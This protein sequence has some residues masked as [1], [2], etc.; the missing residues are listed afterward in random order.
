MSAKPLPR[1]DDELDAQFWE[2]CARERLCF[3]RCS[4]CGTWRHLPR[5][6]CARC[7]S[8][9]WEWSESSGR[10][11]IFSWTVTHQA[12]FPAFAAEV[13]YAVVIVELE[14]GVRMVSRVRDLPID[15]LA[16]DLPVEVSFERV[17]DEAALPYFRPRSAA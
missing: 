8:T 15:A 1:P 5:R 4:A 9:D 10:G 16:L 6:M 17:T 3:Q 14:E 11:R 7:G 12:S 2:H 13:P